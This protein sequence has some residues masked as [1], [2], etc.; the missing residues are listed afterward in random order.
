[1]GASRYTFPHSYDRLLAWEALRSVVISIHAV[2]LSGLILS[3]VPSSHY[4]SN[5]LP[6]Y[7]HLR[8][9]LPSWTGEG[10]LKLTDSLTWWWFSFCTQSKGLTFWDWMLILYWLIRNHLAQGPV[11]A[12]LL[13][14]IF[15]VLCFC[16]FL[17]CFWSELEELYVIPQHLNVPLI[18]QAHK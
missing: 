12:M 16:F 8:L 13:V 17:F 14:G 7:R 18:C 15:S 3:F 1:M 2:Y 10:H 4:L 11:L 9:W 6:N 5:Y